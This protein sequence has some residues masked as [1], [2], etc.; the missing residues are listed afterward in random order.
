MVEHGE[1]GEDAQAEVLHGDGGRLHGVDGEGGALHAGEGG[2]GHGE[3]VEAEGQEGVEEAKEQAI[4]LTG[5]G[6]GRKV[7]NGPQEKTQNASL[8]DRSTAFFSGK[9]YLATS[10]A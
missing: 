6:A 4:L 9:K 3:G 7:A 1:G 5:G 2:G 8:F 10:K